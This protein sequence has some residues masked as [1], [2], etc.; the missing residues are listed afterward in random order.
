MCSRVGKVKLWQLRRRIKDFCIYKS[1]CIRWDWVYQS[2]CLRLTVTKHFNISRY[3]VLQTVFRSTSWLSV[4]KQGRTTVEN[5]ILNLSRVW[6]FLKVISRW[7][8]RCCCTVRTSKKIFFCYFLN[9]CSLNYIFGT[10]KVQ[11]LC[12]TQL[13]LWIFWTNRND[14]M[15]LLHYC[16]MWFYLR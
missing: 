16:P 13:L 6:P 11:L 4:V 14:F 2:K 1:R 15:F 12:C 8:F 5:L 9:N 3:I 10:G 7:S